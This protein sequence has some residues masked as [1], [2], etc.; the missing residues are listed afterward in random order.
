[1]PHAADDSKPTDGSSGRTAPENSGSGQ[2]NPAQ[3]SSTVTTSTSNTDIA[4]NG[5]GVAPEAPKTVPI[6]QKS[7]NVSATQPQAGND[8]VSVDKP[9]QPL[10]GAPEVTKPPAAQTEPPKVATQ[11]PLQPTKAVGIAASAL[12]KK[13]NPT[14]TKP[15]A[16]PKRKDP[17]TQIAL[18]PMVA[19]GALAAA[20][21][22]AARPNIP[23]PAALAP[24]MPPPTAAMLSTAS[25]PSLMSTM[26][27]P[28]PP[29]SIDPV[30]DAKTAAEQ[31]LED[32]RRPLTDLYGPSLVPQDTSLADAR[33]RL[34]TA[35][36]QTYQLREAFTRRVYEKYRV[37]L[38]PPP[39]PEAIVKGIREN[40]VEA[41]KRIT[42]EIE[43]VKEDKEIE[44][45]DV[46][47]VTSEL[48]SS[49]NLDHLMYITAGLSVV[50]LPEAEM[51]EA[52][53]ATYP[54]RAPV[55]PETGARSRGVSQASATAG[56]LTLDRTRR[57]LQLH[58]DR[59]RRKQVKLTS[60]KEAPSLSHLNAPFSL[61]NGPSTSAGSSLLGL[62]SR[63]SKSKAAISASKPS[64]TSNRGRTSSAIPASVLLGLSPAAEQ[65]NQKSS[66]VAETAA[67]SA[68]R[69]RGTF[70]PV[71]KT[72]Q[73]RLR[74]PHPESMGGRRRAS[75]SQKVDSKETFHE[76]FLSM[77]LPPLPVTKE[78]LERKPLELGNPNDSA[79][80]RAK[81]AVREIV[82]QFV[83][84]AGKQKDTT[85]IRLL[86]SLRRIANE[87]GSSETT[88]DTEG[89]RPGEAPSP[90]APLDPVIAFCVLHSVG[91]I[92]RSNL[93]EQRPAFQMPSISE[94][95]EVSDKLQG[96]HKKLS[97]KRRIL[98]EEVLS[99][100]I[101]PT[102]DKGGT[103]DP[104]PQSKKQRL[105]TPFDSEPNTAP[106]T[107][108]E[109]AGVSA[110]NQEPKVPVISLRG[111][112]GELTSEGAEKVSPDRAKNDVPTQQVSESRPRPS[113]NQRLSPVRQRGRSTS[114]SG[115]TPHDAVTFAFLQSQ[116]AR[117]AGSRLQGYV[118]GGSSLSALPLSS[119]LQGGALSALHHPAGDLASARIGYLGQVG[120]QHQNP[121]DLASL[122][123]GTTAFENMSSFAP[124]AL[125]QQSPALLGFTMEEREATARAMY[126]RDRQTAALLQQPTTAQRRFSHGQVPTFRQMAGQ[127]PVASMLGHKQYSN[128]GQLKS[129]VYPSTTTG[130]EDN[131][132]AQ[133]VKKSSDERTRSEASKADHVL[134]E[135]KKT[136]AKS[137]LPPKDNHVEPH[138]SVGKLLEKTAPVNKSVK[139]EVRTGIQFFDPEKTSSV[140]GENAKLIKAGKFFEVIAK[141]GDTAE[142]TKALDYMTAVGVA[143]PIPKT[144]VLT[145]LK[146]RLS[147]VGKSGGG[148]SHIPRETVASAILVWLWANH[149]SNFQEAFDKSGRMDVDPECKW[150]VQAAIDTC[151]RELTKDI[152][153]SMARNKGP[154]AEAAA[155]RKAQKQNGSE[156]EKSAVSAKLKIHAAKLVTR[157]LMTE[158][159]I[160]PTMDFALGN[161]QDLVEY[162]DEAR[163]CALRLKAQERV[164]LA[165]VVSRKA[166][167]TESFSHAYTSSM[168]R[169]GEA[170]GHE[171]LF[172]SVQIEK[173]NVSTM[174]P[175]DIF[176]DTDQSW[177]DPCRPEAGYTPGMGAEQLMR[178]AHARAMIQKSLKRLQDKNNIRGG[179]P[180]QG[181]YTDP[182]SAP[183]FK[184]KPIPVSP[185][186]GKRRMS[187]ITEPPVPPGTG[188]APATSMKQYDP[189]HK[190]EPLAWDSTE[191]ENQ[192]YGRFSRTERPR[193]V[194]LS[195]SARSTDSKSK[196]AR[197]SSVH[198]PVFGVEHEETTGGLRRG[199]FEIAWGDVAGIFSSVE[200]PRK[201]IRAAAADSHA[202]D[203]D[204]QI[205]APYCSKMEGEEPAQNDDSDSEEVLYSEEEILAR[206]QEVLDELKAKLNAYLEAK[207]LQQERRKK[208]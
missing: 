101:I 92:G 120:N 98:S 9:R 90:D 59:R 194:S 162:L 79:P 37:C 51:P 43:R 121:Y 207:K 8:R 4:E 69:S 199:T 65:L 88:H 131:P 204:A 132:V 40:P 189:G 116:V 55:N 198:Q 89:L 186:P 126:A 96:M 172:E 48:G 16:A 185:R 155:A 54:E 74:H 81:R 188:S 20:A 192:P 53:K 63:P 148:S 130:T 170:L 38:K 197:S 67:M 110:P 137:T 104:G 173:V 39:A 202:V 203:Y 108:E 167:V 85:K 171:K 109:N 24:H 47:E 191:L 32:Q 115:A 136:E 19:V 35:I 50:I 201:T 21:S 61:T 166:T 147:S 163:M 183:L 206:H 10:V 140:D 106:A 1:M 118:P 195:L 44:K 17:P 128:G 27:V 6:P 184:A 105:E 33:K 141:T 66:G 42:S 149:E 62:S 99:Q 58:L 158:L 60:G 161:F 70:M 127:P 139:P 91:L 87:N 12:A 152:A 56:E 187:Q 112:G 181:P 2:L 114:D 15:A 86:H 7:P 25:N 113:N 30:V 193:S 14:N 143:V 41:C 146:E 151:F 157:A 71:A 154:F 190:S 45:K 73:Q 165:A 182:S 160:D 129:S 180:N 103:H 111:G 80:D 93:I 49:D 134:L 5:A 135:S 169:G 175:Y 95:L 164:L 82:G 77:T 29:S 138:I 124:M 57:A 125:G 159:R 177:E 168:V 28:L 97:G 176:S 196:K 150:L 76:D 83:D 178:R 75:G 64:I 36:E 46:H 142:H 23:P 68:L 78:R 31:A 102:E 153:D 22:L 72:P 100:T 174:L 208:K 179:A 94:G 52:W 122:V 107:A 145:P 200:L 156:G 133:N 123:P 11:A 18:P 84:D 119:Q 26:S 144:L 3:A 117:A 205:Y 34:E 13:V